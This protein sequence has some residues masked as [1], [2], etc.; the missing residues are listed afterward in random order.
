MRKI[1]Y[2]SYLL[3][4]KTPVYGNAENL[5]KLEKIKSLGKGDSCNVFKFSVRN[6]CG[7]HVDAPA[8]FFAGARK[9]SDYSAGELSFKKPCS[10]H[11]KVKKNHV[12]KLDEIKERIDGE[13]DLVLLK[14]GFGRMRSSKS[15]SV[16]NP[17]VNPDI[18]LWLRKERPNVRAI[19]MD[20]ISVSSYQ[21]RPL[22]REAHRAFLN[23]KGKG[24]PILII[25]DMDLSCDLS[26]LEKVMVAPLMIK[27]I[28]SAPCTVLGVL[29]R[30]RKGE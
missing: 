26:A 15:Y 11:L 24:R 6:H 14:T 21:N 3:D 16:N 17:G 25:E 23:P 7:T 9:L 12:I 5:L 2:L 8:H 13:S 10:I 19:G 30:G 18:G 29:N 27:G 20:F 1:Q 4:E 28:D 22:G